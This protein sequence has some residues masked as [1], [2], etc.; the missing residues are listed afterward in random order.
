MSEKEKETTHN[1][2]VRMLSEIPITHSNSVF[3][4]ARSIDTDELEAEGLLVLGYDETYVS[5]DRKDGK[6]S[7]A[8]KKI[9]EIASRSPGALGDL[10]AFVK[11]YKWHQ[12]YIGFAAVVLIGSLLIKWAIRLITGGF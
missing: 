2:V 7:E 6:P 9:S 11:G 3:K 5:S 4:L 10:Y 1:V 12:I 8:R